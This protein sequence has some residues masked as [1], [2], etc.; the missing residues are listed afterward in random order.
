MREPGRGQSRAPLPYD[1]EAGTANV[2][3]QL[4]PALASSS[5]LY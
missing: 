4:V 2:S 5:M 1:D 3:V